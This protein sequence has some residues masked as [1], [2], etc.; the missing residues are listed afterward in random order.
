M[1]NR[2]E[3]LPPAPEPPYTPPTPVQKQQ[4][5]PVPPPRV[6][7]KDASLPRV[8]KVTTKRTPQQVNIDLSQQI[9]D[10]LRKK[11]EETPSHQ[12]PSLYQRIFKRKQN[13]NFRAQTTNHLAPCVFLA[14]RIYNST[15]RKE[16]I[17]I[18]Y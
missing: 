12:A 8:E 3:E 6:E 14:N 18:H 1:L 7:K 4:P 17:L 11:W 10:G 5:V 16:N 2:T 15:S 9:M 13:T